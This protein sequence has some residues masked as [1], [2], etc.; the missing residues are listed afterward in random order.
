MTILILGGTHFLGRHLVEAS[1]R[2]GHQVTLFNRG[3]T[4]PEL[5]SQVTEL[6]GDRDGN[7]TALA[8]KTW[9]VVIDTSGYVP[10]IVRESANLL[11]QSV[12]R[13]VFISSISAYQDF[14]T[15]NMNE[16]APLGKLDDRASEDI[17]QYYGPLKAASE[18]VVQEVF[19][20][21]ALII[22]P[23]L[24]VGPYDPTDRFT[25][26]VQRFS[27][28]GP[29][30]VPGPLERAVQFID[31]RDLAEWT[32][33]LLEAGLSGVYNATGPIQPL[34]MG[35]LVLA[36][37]NFFSHRATPVW[38]EEEYLLDHGVQEWVELPLW[39]SRETNWPGFMTMNVD[40]AVS[41]GLQ[42]RPLRETIRDTWEWWDARGGDKMQAGL[43]TDK[44]QTLL[45]QWESLHR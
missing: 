16:D 7:L 8:G 36:L 35:D 30:L 2:R 43:S 32:I 27:Q 41:Q 38:V 37:Q 25:Y 42:F 17:E 40:R 23:G 6:H 28:S 20:Q 9:D 19:L 39:I 5:F 21:R 14:S 26:W 29:A 15:R 10:R 13:Y 11:K 22:R 44:E 45:R 4:A 33:A 1:Q 34:T 24:I 31:G 18:R 12:S 3:R